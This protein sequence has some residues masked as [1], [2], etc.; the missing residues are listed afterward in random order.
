MVNASKTQYICYNQ[1]GELKSIDGKDIKEVKEFN[2]LGSN[3]TS[4]ERDVQIRLGK[5][6]AALNSLDKIWK[7]SLPA[8]LKR[9]FFRAAVE[10]ILVYGAITWT[11]TTF[12]SKTLDGAY[13][14][15]LQAALNILWKHHPTKK[16]L[17]GDIPPL[18][19]IIR[20]RRLKFAGHCWHSKGELASDLRLWQPTWMR[21][22]AS[23]I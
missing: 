11:L 6:W 9:N 12:L 13:I 1:Q 3:I 8:S 7:S 17:Y 16:E 10:S 5:A 21:R 15:M 19:T 4:T 22:R 14:R 23:V 18:S 20:E 2:Y